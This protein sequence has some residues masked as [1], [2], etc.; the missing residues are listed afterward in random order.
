MGYEH[1]NIII[2]S[3]VDDQLQMENQNLLQNSSRADH[4]NCISYSDSSNTLAVGS[5]AGH[6]FVRY[7]A[8]GGKSQLRWH[9]V[10]VEALCFSADGKYLFSGSRDCFVAT[11]KIETNEIYK[12]KKFLSPVLEVCAS[13]ELDFFA[14]RCNTNEVVVNDITLNQ[15]ITKVTGLYKD[16][17]QIPAKVKC[18]I[19]VDP[20]NGRIVQ[21]GSNVIQFYD[22]SVE[23]E[24]FKL[25]IQHKNIAEDVQRLA[26]DS[27]EAYVTKIAFSHDA[28]MMATT[29]LYGT[30]INL[31][32]WLYNSHNKQY[33][34]TTVVDSPHSNDI[35][36][37]KFIPK[38][39]TCISTC[40]SGDIKVWSMDENHRYM[41]TGVANHRNLEALCFAA[42][43]DGS[44]L[45]V[46][47]PGMISSWD[48]NTLSLLST[49]S[50][51]DLH[52][53]ID[54]FFTNNFQVVI[55]NKKSVL[56]YSLLYEK[57]VLNFQ[58]NCVHAYG[59]PSLNGE[60]VIQTL[61]DEILVLD[62]NQINDD[63]KLFKRL[64]SDPENVSGTHLKIAYVDRSRLI[65]VAPNHH[66]SVLD[67]NASKLVRKEDREPENEDEMLYKKTSTKT[68]PQN[69]YVVGHVK[70]MYY[71]YDTDRPQDAWKELFAN[72]LSHSLTSTHSVFTTFMDHFTM[73]SKASEEVGKIV[74]DSK[75]TAKMSNKAVVDKKDKMDIDVEDEE[76]DPELIAI[77]KK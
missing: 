9:P 22:F 33:T 6:I 40:K 17:R 23:R 13:Q 52:F 25:T 65:V 27:V 16:N 73:K 69:S 7:V 14:V 11:W 47:H 67:L 75:N 32:F 58:V 10:A 62:L 76:L 15:P 68:T 60:V 38:S 30:L 59:N 4:F 49:H 2:Y 43:E 66:A 24:D 37:L 70:T 71:S 42:S 5:S 20:L 48:V 77:L 54:A 31:K 45:V 74:Q 18:S 29:E 19:I 39:Q 34:L 46:V 64:Y 56:V 72:S 51:T 41:C 50:M 28:Q 12:L 36:D 44:V 26:E 35:T 57:V 53:A 63:K 61:T 1:N 3:T 55:A 8:T 21:T